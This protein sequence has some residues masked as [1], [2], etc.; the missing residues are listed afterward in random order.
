M[1]RTQHPNGFTLIELSIVLV[2]IGL[3]VGGILTG[4]DLIRAAGE[5]ATITQI[6]KFNTATNTFYGKYGYLPGD[7]P[8]PTATQFGFAPR[9]SYAGEGDGN[10]IL[11]GIVNNAANANYGW[12][13]GGGETVMFWV[14]L[15]TANGMNINLIDGSFSA[16][17]ATTAAT[18]TGTALTSYFPVAKLGGGNYFYVYSNV[19]RDMTGDPTNYF[20]LSAVTGNF[21]AANC[22]A[23]C[24]QS[25]LGLTVRQAYDIDTKIDDGKPETGRVVAK[26]LNGATADG[27]QWAPNAASDGTTTCFNY[28]NAYALSNAANY[29]TNINCALSFKFQ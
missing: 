24:L 3:I 15:T 26:Y 22:G 2:I 28:G 20:G 25:E 27:G 14:D 13:D 4:A 9:G 10:G 12:V 18:I 6:E 7:I 21:T 23:P 19:F 16:A 17:T 29:G 11:Q 8:N 5:R 1:G